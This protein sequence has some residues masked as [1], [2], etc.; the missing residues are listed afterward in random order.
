MRTRGR[1]GDE[2]REREIVRDGGR[3]RGRFER[4]RGSMDEDSGGGGGQGGTRDE[5]G[6]EE[7]KHKSAGQTLAEHI[8]IP[9]PTRQTAARG[10]P[11]SRHPCR[12]AGLLPDR[13]SVILLFPA[14]ATLS[15][16]RAAD[17]VHRLPR[18]ACARGLLS[19]SAMH[20]GDWPSRPPRPPTS[21]PNQPHRPTLATCDAESSL[22]G[23]L[24]LPPSNHRARN[25][26]PM[27]PSPPISA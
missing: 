11:S 17:V 5:G 6:T 14:H 15:E 7:S 27:L 4:E 25:M 18:A 2:D 12:P 23:S 16:L 9:R 19:L 24:F 21:D 1:A 22:L 20:A 26:R 13:H 10:N 3:R 8:P